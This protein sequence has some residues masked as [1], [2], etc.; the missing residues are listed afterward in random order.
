MKELFGL[1]LKGEHIRCSIDEQIV[2]DQLD[3]NPDAVQ[4]LLLASGYLK[5]I[6]YQQ[7]DEI[8]EYEEPQYELAIT[9][10]EVRRMFRGLVRDWFKKTQKAYND[11][12]KAL[13]LQDV[14]EMN[15]FMNRV[16][17]SVFSYF[18]AGGGTS[19]DA[20]ERFGHGL[21]LGLLVELQGE[22]IITSNR[23]SGF[24]RYDI[25]LEPVEIGQSDAIILEFKVIDPES[26]A[27]LNATV[28]NAL[29]Q[30]RHKQYDAQ[31]LARGFRPDQI[32]AYGFAFQGKQVLIGK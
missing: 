18:D 23:E 10:Q 7:V 3:G 31:L 21:V 14:E 22:Y 11:F 2:Y 30:I 19:A 15:E 27:D 1:L 28:N 26:E 4:S 13:L 12:I 16:A 24:G 17:Q 5:V 32:R 9:N 29:E 6:Q 25:M 8:P 20:P